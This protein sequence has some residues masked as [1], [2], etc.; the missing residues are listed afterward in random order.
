[1]S[2]NTAA[3][4]TAISMIII[5]I[6]GFVTAYTKNL[7]MFGYGAMAVVGF[8]GVAMIYDIWSSSR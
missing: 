6:T 4:A 5:S 7:M 3:Y 8:L 1:M 2:T